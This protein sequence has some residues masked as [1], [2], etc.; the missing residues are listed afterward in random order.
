MTDLRYAI[1]QLRRNPGFTAG[2]V[3]PLALAMGCAASVLTLTD[4]VLYRPTGVR[5]P[6]RV[7]AVYTFSRAQNRYLSDSY[8]DFQDIASLPL[9]DAAAAYVRTALS[10]RIGEGAERMNTELVT[11][12]YFRAAGIEPALGRALTAQDDAPGAAPVAMASYTLWETRF[13]RSPSI[14][15]S[16]LWINRVPFTIVG[17]MPRGYQGM[18]LDWYGDCALWTPLAHFNRLFPSNTAPDFETRREIPMFMMLARLHA[19][20]SVRTAQ[21]ALDA[22]APRV[23]ARP[24]YRFI[25]FPSTEARFYPTYRAGTLRFLWML[26]A[27]SAIAVAIACANLA[28]LLLARASA[29]QKE[30]AARLAIGASRAQIVRQL[31]V[32]NGAV[33]LC[34][35]ALSIPVALGAAYWLRDAPITAGFS[36]ALDLS[37]DWRALALGMAAGLTTAIL[38]GVAPAMRASRGE[39]KPAHARRGLSR[40]LFLVAQ[41]AGAMTILIPAALLVQNLHNL[42]RTPLGYESSGVLLGSLDAISGGF[43]TPEEVDRL[44]K[45]LLTEL[46][47]Q[48][49]EA[50]LASS[51]LPTTMRSSLDA[52]ADQLGWKPVAFDWTSSG[53]FELLRTPV[54][55]G[56]AI[57]DSDDRR[58]LPVVVVNQSA[59]AAFWPGQNP[60][61]RSI[62]VRGESADRI[63]VG[64]VADSR[65]R[66]LG[67]AQPAQPCLFLPLLQ[68][69]TVT[70]FEIH[71]RTVGPPMSFAGAMRSITARLAPEASLGDVRTLD[72]QARS[73][74]K[75]MVTAAEST[76][77]VSV[78]GIGLAL[79]GLFAVSAYRVSQ[80]KKEIAIRIAIGARTPSV[81]ASFTSRGVWIGLMGCALGLFPAL[82]AAR[83][84]RA[85]IPGVTEPSAG[86]FVAGAIVLIIA[87]GV[88]AFAASHSIVRVRPADVLRVQ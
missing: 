27:I 29:R 26:M 67:V 45:N 25:A 53:Y 73:G 42:T 34:A 16:V 38:A 3:L 58:A 85:S 49:R 1:R 83:L 86:L 33:A 55:E 62:R 61:G 84:L 8:P 77:A 12:D 18:L 69:A 35:A 47:G 2:A 56:R 48:G 79:A 50:A 9:F 17:V 87:S 44:S 37:P 64:M 5:D 15:G 76:G 11:G 74:L 41:V 78:L 63:V 21:A 31:V 43:T 13:A 81:I 70:N 51:A 59:A 23:V 71:V 68:K 80:R 22:L 65:F 46:R 10:V 66:P 82:W 28:S 88:A 72:E 19:G 60:V 75:P 6:G 57:L 14:L 32:E 24:D 20:V 30:F 52:S 54:L 4:A 36:L 39:I 40:D 7:A